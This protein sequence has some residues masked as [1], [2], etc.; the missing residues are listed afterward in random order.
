M[1]F[2]QRMIVALSIKVEQTRKAAISSFN[3]LFF[4][5]IKKLNFDFFL[6]ICN[7]SLSFFLFSLFFSL[8][9]DFV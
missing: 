2:K 4:F 3:H 5:W 6:N 8:N 1:F 7:L 9:L